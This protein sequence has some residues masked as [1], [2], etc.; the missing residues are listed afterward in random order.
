MRQKYHAKEPFKV[1]IPL[2][3]ARS[4]YTP[5]VV[6]FSTGGI[7]MY[8]HL[9]LAITM[10]LGLNAQ[11]AVWN[12]VND[13]SPAYEDRYAD[14][15]R[16]E[17][18]ADFFSRKTLPNGQSNPYLGLRMDCADTVYTMRII[19]AYEN[20]LPVVFQ[21]PT[22]A[23]KTVSNKMSRWD[24]KNEIQRV[25]DFLW[26]IY[27]LMSTRSL[28]NDTYPVAVNRDA[29]RSGGLI[30][31]TKKNHHSWTLKEMLPIGVPHLVYNSVIGSGSG[32]GLKERQSW[33]NPDWVFEGDFS[34]AGNAGFRG[35]RPESSINRSVWNVPGY[36]EEQY[37]I[38]L[39]GWVRTVQNRLALRRETDEQM[40]K[41]I[42][43]A[44]CQGLADR[45]ASVKEGL[46]YLAKNPRCMAYEVY[47][48]YSTPSRDR[49][50]FDDLMS[51]RRSYRE[52]M[53]INGGNQLPADLKAQ[54]N[55]IFP[56][57]SSSATKETAQMSPSGIDAN[58]LCVTQ[59]L[60]GQRMDLAE[61]KRRM[62]AGLISN[63]P[64]DGAEYRWGDLRGPSQRARSCKSWDAWSP[65]LT[66]E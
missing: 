28:P 22:A 18:R 3:L 7:G 30:L 37:R 36:S 63:N 16:R 33:P 49:R 24:G 44:A 48:N 8:R 39:K 62:F 65:D 5:A 19:F 13:W 27:G 11:A 41:R 42:S 58:S 61:F 15:V 55:K 32:S 66:Q 56:A 1:I 6:E 9:I 17:W 54:M 2:R 47:D 14:W 4:Q 26:F 60:S 52:I 20:R 45:V 40:L 10:L 21:D 25:R 35:W 38:P 59:H 31:T 53:Q 12:E 23:G 34:P 64:H 43:A 50:I 57:I 46:D 29:I 51:L